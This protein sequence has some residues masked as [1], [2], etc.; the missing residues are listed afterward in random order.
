[1]NFPQL[2]TERLGLVKIEEKHIQSY[3]EIMS[4]DEVTKFYGMNSLKNIE[5]ATK[6]VDLF[7][8][9]F[10]KSR[11]IRWGILMK[12][13]NRLIGTLGLNNLNTGSKKAEIG[14]ELHPSFWGKGIAAEAITE[15]LE[16]SFQE[17]DLF[18]IGAITFPD[19][20]ASNK[21]LE[22]LGFTNEGLLRGYLY[23]N[24]PHDAFIYSLLKSEWGK[25][26]KSWRTS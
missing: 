11:G 20:V 17:L 9:T 4:K 19:N 5:E 1:M 26:N 8:N 12:D 10:N 15:V 16:Y 13:L 14:Y 18:R 23:H 22:K 7:E 25:N 2:E 6:I 24:K 3:Y 21:L